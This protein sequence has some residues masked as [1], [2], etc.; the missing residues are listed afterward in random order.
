MSASIQNLGSPGSDLSADNYLAETVR[1]ILRG[2]LQRPLE[3]LTLQEEGSGLPLV[4][5]RS[6]PGGL[7]AVDALDLSRFGLLRLGPN[8]VGEAGAGLL[9]NGLVRTPTW[10]YVGVGDAEVYDDDYARVPASGWYWGGNSST[11]VAQFQH[12]D[13]EGTAGSK[14]LLRGVAGVLE[15]AEF[16]KATG[17]KVFGI[18]LT[19]GTCQVEFVLGWDDTEDQCVS[20]AG[21]HFSWDGG[22]QRFYTTEDMEAANYYGTWAGNT[23]AVNKGGTGLASYT[24]GDLLY[25]SGATTLSKLGIGTAGK[26]LKVNA[27]ATAP[28]WGDGYT[29][30]LTTKGDLLTYTTAEARLAVGSDGTVLTADSAQSAGVKWASLGATLTRSFNATA[31]T[32]NY[33]AATS[34]DVVRVRSSFGGTLVVTLPL[35]STMTTGQTI[36]VK[37]VTNGGGAVELNLSDPW[38]GSSGETFEDPTSPTTDTWT[39]LAASGSV[40]F[41]AITVMANV[42]GNFWEVLSAYGT[43]GYS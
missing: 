37:S 5:R 32:G 40:S 12:R 34:D 8:D 11:T 18:G 7:G 31:K 22:S 21:H 41:A 20:F 36:T 16:Y 23:I 15:G 27:G 24:T 10:T 3:G 39:S 38:D 29:S 19:E 14:F 25:A 1:Q 33:T 28:E 26:V 6:Y 35:I 4:V 42:A 13:A 9:S 30:P 43:W 17:E 2:E